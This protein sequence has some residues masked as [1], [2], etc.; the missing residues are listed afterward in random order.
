MKYVEIKI[1]FHLILIKKFLKYDHLSLAYQSYLVSI[2]G[3]QEPTTYSEATKDQKWVEAMKSEIQALEDNKSWSVTDLPA[4][5][6][7]I[8]CGWIYKI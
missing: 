4:G 5:K 8:G 6:K 3:L 1:L 7:A 2:Y